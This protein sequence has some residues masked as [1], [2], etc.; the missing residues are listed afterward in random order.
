MTKKHLLQ[1]AYNRARRW[2]AFASIV[3]FATTRERAYREH[4]AQVARRAAELARTPQGNFRVR[5]GL[6]EGMLWPQSVVVG[7]EFAPKVLGTY[8]LELQGIFADLLKNGTATS[9]IDV[10]AAEGYYAV[11]ACL[12]NSD[13]KV[14]AYEI[15]NRA[16]A[17]IREL[18]LLNGVAERLDVTGEFDLRAVD[19]DRFGARPVFLIDIEGEEVNLVDERFAE[20]FAAASIVI[21]VHDF[22]RPGAGRLLKKV[23]S[24]THRVKEIRCSDSGRLPLKEGTGLSAADWAIACGESRPDGNYWLVARPRC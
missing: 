5:S 24:P 14:H 17:G 3:N 19:K 13:V 12:L 18:A 23:L 20:V 16:H 8:E 15:Q 1:N 9:F 7:S 10:G 21:E 6:F 11:G 4:C 22:V 2:P